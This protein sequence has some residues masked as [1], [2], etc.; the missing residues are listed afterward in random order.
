MTDPQFNAQSSTPVNTEPTA[1]TPEAQAAD[2]TKSIPVDQNAKS[3]DNV[4]T[5][6]HAS[7]PVANTDVLSPVAVAAPVAAPV[8]APVAAPA[9]VPI[10][11]PVLTPVST[12]VAAPVVQAVTAP[13]VGPVTTSIQVSLLLETAELRDGGKLE[14][15]DGPP[16]LYVESGDGSWGAWHLYS[17]M[18]DA[19][20]DAEL[21]ARLDKL[22]FKRDW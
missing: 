10:A 7:A 16:R 9:L 4:E 12:T 20:M 21:I 15:H 6:V 8:T 1:P 13:V 19:K 3:G 17:T 18:S 22:G 2:G 5:I 11:A 14:L